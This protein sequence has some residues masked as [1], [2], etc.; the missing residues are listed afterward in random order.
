MGRT[1]YQQT[2]TPPGRT[3]DGREHGD[4]V[5]AVL[6][7]PGTSTTCVVRNRGL[8]PTKATGSGGAH[9][10]RREVPGK[11]EAKDG[12]TGRDW[13]RRGTE[14]TRRFLHWVLEASGAQGGQ[15]YSSEHRI[16]ATQGNLQGCKE[17]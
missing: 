16:H 1:T 2:S 17:N 6:P 7:S 12:S 5:G 8:Q 14:S 13:K 9:Y 11:G 10:G 15:G 3:V 4:C